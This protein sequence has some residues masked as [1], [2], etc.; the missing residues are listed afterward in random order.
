VLRVIDPGLLATIQDAGRPG[1]ESL[2]V[3]VGGACDPWSLGVANALVGNE[4]SAPAIEVTLLGTGWEVVEDVVLG[5]AGADLGASVPEDRRQLEPGRAHLVREGRQLRFDG[6][7]GGGG[8]G[9]RAYVALPGG[10]DVPQVLGGRGT[11][12]RGGF[13]GLD[14]RAL[15]PGD[16]LAPVRRADLRAAGRRWRGPAWPPQARP[17]VARILAG[18]HVDVVAAGALDDLV[19][20]TWTVDPRSDRSGVR[21][22]P[23]EET[24]AL[25]A[26]PSEELVSQP[27]TWG[28]VQLTPDGTPIC[29]LA[30]HGTVG[31]YPVVA[32]VITADR[33]VIGQLAPG[34]SVRFELVDLRAAHFA[35][36]DQR[37]SFDEPAAALR[38]PI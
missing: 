19:S 17:A 3:P 26:A 27:M 5:L 9:A 1:Y 16:E 32:C 18:P 25:L 28:A 22:V 38:R 24:A 37:R 33:A 21:L 4:P 34:E 13:G 30:D 20:T 8:T 29:L 6:A 2:G 35:L 36:R 11:C 31:G 7:V 10:V 15:L 23:V 14:G 12:L